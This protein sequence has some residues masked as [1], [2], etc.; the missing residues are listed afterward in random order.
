MLVNIIHD[1]DDWDDREAVSIV[2]A[3]A[4]AG[5]DDRATVLLVEAVMPETP[6][7]HWAKKLDVMML[8]ITGGRERALAEHQALLAAGGIDLV[9]VTP[10]ETPFA[11]IE[12]RIR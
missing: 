4:D 5:R 1:W 10:T 7:P 2:S 11:I 9:S 8:A 6:E 3:V 12:S